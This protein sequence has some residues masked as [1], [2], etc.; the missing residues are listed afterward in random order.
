[1]KNSDIKILLVDDEPDIIEFLSYNLKKE[2]YQVFSAMNGEDAVKL[3]KKIQPHLI[4]LDVMMPNMDGIETCEEL[5]AISELKKVIIVFLTARSE[6]YSEIAGFNAGADDYIAKP[7]RPKVF[8]SRVQAHLKRF[9]EEKKAD[10]LVLTFGDLV[11]DK[12][13]HIV[14][15]HGDELILPNKEFK[16]LVLL[17]S[18]PKRVFSRD[19]I[20]TTVW[21]NDVIVGDRTIDVHIRKLREKFG[22]KLIK[23]VKGIGYKFEFNE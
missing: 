12:E 18:A 16:L 10:S 9:E 4:V 23:T 2:E 17:T 22:N 15:Y 21:G 19:E 20:Y 1:M 3:A 13:K 11:I 5:R 6:D 7:V 14:L 8:L